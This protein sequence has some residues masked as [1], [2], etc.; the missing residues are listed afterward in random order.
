MQKN[1][2]R[3]RQTRAALLAAAAVAVL[4]AA[5]MAQTTFYFENFES[6]NRN[7]ISQDP[8]IAANCGGGVVWTEVPPAGWTV[9]DCG[10]PSYY[11][12]VGRPQNLCAD[13]GICNPQCLNDAGIL[14]WEG[15]AFVNKEFWVRVAG[16][17]TRGLFTLGTGNVAVADPDEWD[18]ELNPATTCGFY[19]AFMKSPTISLT[20]ADLSTLSFALASS[21]RPEAF[22]DGDGTNNQTATIRATYATPSGDVVVEV[23]KFDSDQQSPTFHSDNQNEQVNLNALAL[24][25]PAGATSVRFEFGLTNA[26]NDW[27]WAVDNLVVSAQVNGTP[28]NMWSEDFEG[29]TLLPAQEEGSANPCALAYCGQPVYTHQGP[30]GVIVSL[31][32]ASTGGVPDWAGWSFAPVA[33]WNCMS[34][35]N[36]GQFVLGDGTVAI[37]DGDEWTDRASSGT[38]STLLTTPSINISGRFSDLIVLGFDSSWRPEP[39]QVG[40]IIA[41]FQTST[42]PVTS[43]LARFESIQVLPNGQFNPNFKAA[44][45]SEQLNIPVRV[46]SGATSVVLKFSYLGGNNWWWA[47]D[48]LRLFEGIVSIALNAEAPRTSVMALA[49]SVDFAPCFAPWAPDAPL[50]WTESAFFPIGCSANCGRTEWRGWSF[51]NREWW[52][53][54]VDDQ[55]RSEFT[56]ARGFVAVADPDEWDDQGN[57]LSVFDAFMTS[58]SI[59]LPASFSS[60]A[61]NFDSS[62]RP[63]CCDDSTNGQGPIA[64]GQNN[65]TATINAIYATPNGTITVPVLVFQSDPAL[66]DF[67]PDATNEAVSLGNTVLQV[68]PGATSVSFEF[69]LTKARN[70]WWWAVDNLAL[71]ADGNTLFSEGFENPQGLSPAPT[72]NPPT[73]ICTYFSTVSGQN[74][75]FTASSTF[76]NPCNR[77]PDFLTWNAWLTDAWASAGGGLRS[78]FGARTAYVSDFEQLSGCEG[79]TSF[80]S[81]TFD[82]RSINAGTLS[83]S[84]RSGWFAQAA[85]RS[86]LEVSYDGGPFVAVL[87]WNADAPVGSPTRKETQPDEVVTVSLNNPANAANVRYRFVDRNSGWWAITDLALTGDVG[88]EICRADFNRDGNLDPDDLADYITA[89]F[90]VPA[91]LS[92]DF[93][94]DSV[95][96]PDDLADYITAFFQGC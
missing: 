18:D 71:V 54:N 68:P 65:Q 72:E 73:T 49:P 13:T 89:F 51:A 26:G 59:A 48:D 82:V 96:D 69:G 79:S 35:Q 52:S 30:N 84:F 75:G 4:P 47:I 56:R 92:A 94:G 10:V 36:R 70:D 23:L 1:L 9:I 31:D 63:E 95:V 28:T 43:Q 38:L 29:V 93:N 41:E 74:S 80:D 46:P 67:H 32:P 12:R 17:Q 24:N 20:G 14:E 45:L 7:L 8:T 40:E 88:S 62:W 90:S 34:G 61:F 37:A 85:H 60:I 76:T 22:D 3:W 91:P 42:G 5:L 58:P 50:G 33:F 19:N 15:W 55:A 57:N 11:C 44:N 25:A 27:W 66:P 16:D 39:D 6:A 78:A 64:P 77:N 83:I 81:P 86:T 87:D 21:W 53:T 2:P